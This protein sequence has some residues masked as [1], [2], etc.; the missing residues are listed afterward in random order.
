MLN[1]KIFDLGEKNNGKI[2]ID[3]IWQISSEEYFGFL[4]KAK[5]ND[6]KIFS[7]LTSSTIMSLKI[8]THLSHL[9]LLY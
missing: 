4:F 7:S 8:E 3:R 1:S 9:N 5:I 2:K 6:Q